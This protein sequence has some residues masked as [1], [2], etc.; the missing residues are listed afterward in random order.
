MSQIQQAT[1]AAYTAE[2]LSQKQLTAWSATGE[3]QQQELIN[4]LDTVIRTVRLGHSPSK[5]I[6]ETLKCLEGFFA[7]NEFRG[8]LRLINQRHIHV[9]LAL[10]PK[11]R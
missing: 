4:I 2:R 7:R 8:D 3:E 5:A 10:P 11:Y 1:F 6:K 9:R